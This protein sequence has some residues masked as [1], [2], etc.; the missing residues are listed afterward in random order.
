MDAAS[1]CKPASTC[2]HF[3]G[4]ASTAP[5]M[6]RFAMA[7]RLLNNRPRLACI[8]AAVASTSIVAGMS[9]AGTSPVGVGIG[10]WKVLSRRERF[11]FLGV[12]FFSLPIPKVTNVITKGDVAGLL[13]L[14][15][16]IGL[17]IRQSH[18]IFFY[19]CF[20]LHLFNVIKFFF[21][22]SWGFR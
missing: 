22:D 20:Y 17:C 3:P 11:F 4:P 1:A 5:V 13:L 8:A 16:F 10:R 14:L 6:M 15:N 2:L 7:I 9:T 21:F 18:D 19:L 12:F